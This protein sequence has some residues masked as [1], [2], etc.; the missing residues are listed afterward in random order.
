MAVIQLTRHL[1]LQGITRTQIA[2]AIVQFRRLQLQVVTGHEGAVTVVDI[3]ANLQFKAATGNHNAVFTVVQLPG[4]YLHVSR[5]DQSSLIM[6]SQPASDVQCHCALARECSQVAVVQPG[7]ADVQLLGGTNLAAPVVQLVG[8]DIYLCIADDQP[9]AVVKR[10][11]N[12][13]SRILTGTDQAFRIACCCCL[14]AQS[15][16]GYQ[17]P[18]MVIQLFGGN[19]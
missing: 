6:V 5:A 3:V 18:V 10:I 8:L 17:L 15:C 7:G 11:D 2:I 1:G 16:L 19:P 13:Q 12:N 9:F 4:A 14:Q